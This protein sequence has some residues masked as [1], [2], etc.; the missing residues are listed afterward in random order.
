MSILRP[1]SSRLEYSGQVGPDSAA[2]PYLA[3]KGLVEAVNLAILLERPLLVKG[4]PGCGKSSLAAAV[5]ADL[6]RQ[7]GIKWPFEYWP[8]KSTSRARDGLY[9]Y[10]AVARL[11]D[12]QLAAMN[13]KVDIDMARYV[14]LG[15]L[16]RALANERRTIVLIDEIDRADIDF[17]NDLL[18]EL[19]ELRFKVQE[20]GQWKEAKSTPIVFITSNDEKALPH[21]FL[22]RCLFYY[23]EFPD[24]KR[25][26]EIMKIRF[27]D[28][29]PEEVEALITSRSRPEIHG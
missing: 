21:A 17:P 12:A 28:V 14:H 29:P 22:R 7:H 8:I 4:A 26:L 11:R 18:V 25:F 16:G 24:Q 20:T 10:D 9:N 23:I 2:R 3:D 13:Q 15:P 19:D 1:G 6:G 5:A 27:P